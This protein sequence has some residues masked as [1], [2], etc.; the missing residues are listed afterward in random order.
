MSATVINVATA[1]WDANGSANVTDEV[2]AGQVPLGAS[3]QFGF[4]VVPIDNRWML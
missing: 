2:A 1:Y 3:A 4:G